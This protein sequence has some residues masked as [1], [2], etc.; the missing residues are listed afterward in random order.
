MFFATPLIGAAAL[1]S[2]FA[3]ALPR[4]DSAI[5][6]EV[7][8]SAPNGILI[9]DTAALA[10][11]TDSAAST[12]VTSVDSYS[13]GYSSQ[14]GS[15]W[16]S[17]QTYSA[18]SSVVTSV[19]SDSAYSSQAD[20]TLST[21]AALATSVSWEPSG[22][23]SGSSSWGND[24]YGSCVQQ[25]MASYGGPS[26]SS[27]PPTSA[28]S[29]SD[30]GS[31]GATHT[32]I[33]APTQGVLRFVPFA[34]NA[35]VGDT[36]LF[37]WGANNHTVTKSSAL[38]PCNKTSDDPF[39]TGERN[40]DFTFR[41][42]VNDTNP[43]FFY[44]GTPTHCEKGMFGIINPP[45]A[46]GSPSSAASMMS[47]L[48][49]NDSAIGNYATY[50]NSQTE[51]NQAAAAWGSSMDMSSLPA[52]SHSYVAENIMYTRN[53]LA[54][55]TEVMMSDGKIDMG[56]IDKTRLTLPRDFSAALNSTGATS[57]APPAST[58]SSSASSS[59]STTKSSAIVSTSSSKVLVGLVVGLATFMML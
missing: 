27:T 17:S 1:L 52:W 19:G 37:M 49:I 50:T 29:Y 20:Q 48:A 10:T 5:G 42:V 55:N 53:F 15:G 3:V 12:L 33:V 21:S 36:L 46:L 4:P 45:N 38:T 6:N 13:N 18:A 2:S 44:C 16:A 57:S 30:S 43:L 35:S 22:Y 56:K 9:S 8:V 40:K 34:L 41:Q 58:S 25:C 24:K 47:S 26:A 23:G 59:Q 54:A 7:A 11:Q 32:I 28:S 39:T 31:S 51:S 14:V